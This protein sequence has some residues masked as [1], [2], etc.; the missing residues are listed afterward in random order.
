MDYL[1]IKKKDSERYINFNFNLN[2]NVE[3][4]YNLDFKLIYNKYINIKLYNDM[5]REGLIKE[6]YILLDRINN[7]TISMMSKEFHKLP[8]D[9]KRFAHDNIIDEQIYL[10]NKKNEVFLRTR[11]LISYL[12]RAQDLKNLN[13]DI[14]FFSLLSK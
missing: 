13:I 9:I 3:N 14:D 11:T 7:L 1:F 12:V 2:N 10:M 8:S 6:S 4:L 5:L